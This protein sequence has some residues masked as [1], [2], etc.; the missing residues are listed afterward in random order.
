MEM[1]QKE[2]LV[3]NSPT[4]YLKVD[5]WYNFTLFSNCP[6]MGSYIQLYLQEAPSACDV[7]SVIPEALP[8]NELVL[9]C[10]IT[11]ITGVKT[12]DPGTY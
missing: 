1:R 4:K 7:E 11:V 10:G 3:L 6:S 12:K 9:F 5:F 8:W 2:M